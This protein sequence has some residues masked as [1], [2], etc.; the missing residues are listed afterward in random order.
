M[1]IYG[2][3]L[4]QNGGSDEILVVIQYQLHNPFLEKNTLLS[5]FNFPQE[6]FRWLPFHYDSG[7][8]D[9]AVAGQ[10]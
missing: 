5:E 3:I 9:Q 4:N 7:L 1:K 2:N 6:V 10:S 8:A